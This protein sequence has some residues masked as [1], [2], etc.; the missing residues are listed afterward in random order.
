MIMTDL[1]IVLSASAFL[2]LLSCSDNKEISTGLPTPKQLDSLIYFNEQINYGNASEEV[3]YFRAQ[4][5]LRKNLIEEALKDLEFCIRQDSMN[6]DAHNLYADVQMGQLNLEKAKSHY[7]FVIEKDSLNEK[8]YLGMGKMYAILDNYAGAIAYLNQSLKINP[9]NSEVY[10]MKGIIYR[11]DFE[12]SGRT[13]SWDIALSS[14]QTAIEQDPNNYSAYINLGVMYD[15]LGDSSALD[16]YNSAL[17]IYPESMEAWYNKGWYFQNRGM[18]A[19]AMNCYQTIVKIDSSWSE[20]YY[21]MGYI[22]LQITEQYDSAI[23]YFNKAVTFDPEYFQA[24]NNI[25][26]AYEKSEDFA[27]AKFYYT[28]AIEINPDYQLAKNNLNSIMNK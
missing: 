6:L 19:D 13:E 18:I 4:F 27:N 1:K 14:F 28:K 20:P 16:Y 24:Y 15:K 23:Y 11:S 8:A 25:G 2:V 9:Y 10:F 17:E 26:L 21:N 7:E 12:K 5:Y 3:I 22:H